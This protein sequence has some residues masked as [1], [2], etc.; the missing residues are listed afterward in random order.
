MLLFRDAGVAFVHVPKTCGS[1][2]RRYLSSSVGGEES[3]WGVESP[4]PGSPEAEA[5]DKVDMAHYTA[6]MIRDFRGG[7]FAE[8]SGMRVFSVARNPY[9][10]AISAYN[11]FV[12]F[13]GDSGLAPGVN[14]FMDYLYCIHD[15]LYRA[16]RDGYLYIHGAPQVRFHLPG[17]HLIWGRDLSAGLSVIFGREM[18]F[19]SEESEDRPLTS[20]EMRMVERV[21]SEDLEMWKRLASPSSPRELVPDHE[22]PE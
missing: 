10:R 6:D 21:Y 2:L 19:S 20:L 3:W 22:V 7:L 4:A 5:F 16:S 17:H 8:L 11:Q 18:S 15:E 1:A 13:F 12:K 14:E 9:S